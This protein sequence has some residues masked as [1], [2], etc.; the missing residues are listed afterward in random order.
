MTVETLYDSSAP[1]MKPSKTSTFF[2]TLL[3]VLWWLSWI[4]AIGVGFVFIMAALA[5]FGF[6]PIQD[7][8][9]DISPITALL[10][11]LSAFVAIGALLIILKQLKKICHTLVLGDPFVPENAKRLR[12]IWITVAIAELFRLFSGFFIPVVHSNTI[13]G[14]QV[15]ISMEFRFY[16][17][18][19]VLALMVLAEVFREG[20]RLRRE[21]KLTI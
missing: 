3:S 7:E 14:E 6:Q 20:A 12:T 10:F 2:N 19:L 15:S 13:A 11:C 8:F 5:S 16:V 18:F 17:W 1:I 21:Q 4:F 9:K